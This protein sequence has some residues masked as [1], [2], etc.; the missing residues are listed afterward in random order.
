VPFAAALSEHPVPAQAVGEVVGQVLEQ[1]GDAPDLAVLFVTAPHAGALEDAAATIRTTLRPGALV[2]AAAVAVIGG[3][4]EVEEQPA[5]SLWAARLP[6]GTTV[7]PVRL[8]DA[9][10]VDGLPADE[11]SGILLVLADP[12]T[13]AVDEFL[14]RTAAHR[15]ATQVV[16]GLASAAGRPGGNRLVLDDRIHTDGAV[17]VHLAGIDG[18][19]TIVSQGCRPIGRPFVITGGEANVIRELAGQPPLTRLEEVVNGLAPEERELVREGIQI[20]CVIDEQLEEFQPGDF[21]VRSV[22]GADRESGAIAIGQEVDIGATVQFQVRDAATAD[23]ELRQLL[24]GRQGSGAL[25]FTCNGRGVRLFGGPDHDASLVDA[26]VSDHANAGMFCA[27]EL[28]PVGGRNF[29]HG[30]TASV[31]LFADQPAAESRI[32]ADGAG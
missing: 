8:G 15:P 11:P 1:I 12:F 21:L 24:A 16:G 19:T 27:G 32:G 30:F 7:T 18:A 2:G 4:R 6:T 5:V 9:T 29:V 25:L 23:E 17:A 13:F 31:V 22:L 20:G 10:A 14:E 3:P 26:V 28:G